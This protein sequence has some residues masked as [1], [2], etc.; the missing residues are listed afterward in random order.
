[1]LIVNKRKLRRNRACL[2]SVL[3]ALYAAFVFSNSLKPAA[4]SSADSS[5]ALRL[6]QDFLA[7]GGID[8][9]GLTEHLI[10]KAAHFTEYAVFGVLLCFCLRSYPLKTGQRIYFQLMPG[11]FVPFADETIQLFVPGRSGQLSDVWLDAAGVAFG[12]AAGRAFYLTAIWMNRKR[13]GIKN[14]K[15]L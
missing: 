9:T 10:R 7:A 3:T 6:M 15:K 13:R 12:L 1:M 11:F 8:G 5:E 14:D 4:V 2:W